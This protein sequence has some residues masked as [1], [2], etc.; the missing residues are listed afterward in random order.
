MPNAVV[1]LEPLPPHGPFPWYGDCKFIAV[2][3]DEAT[4]ITTFVA[5]ACKATE[6]LATACF[7]ELVCKL[8]IPQVIDTNLSED[9]AENLKDELDTCLNQDI[10]HNPFID[11]N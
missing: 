6:D 11:A 2:L 4:K 3:T 9:K 5:M 1:H 7:V 10:P 8:S